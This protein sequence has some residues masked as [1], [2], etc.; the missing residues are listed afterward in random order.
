MISPTYKLSVSSHPMTGILGL[1]VVLLVLTSQLV[2]TPAKLAAKTLPVRQ[3]AAVERE[4]QVFNDFEPGVR[5]LGNPSPASVLGP[6]LKM[7]SL[8][9]NRLV[10]ACHDGIKIWDTQRN[11]VIQSLPL[12]LRNSQCTA[13]EISNDKKMVAAS[14]SSYTNLN[15][16]RPGSALLLDL[17]L[18]QLAEFIL[19]EEI[20]DN[21]NRSNQVAAI[22]FS[23][24]DSEIALA[25]GNKIH[26]HQV[27]NADL[28][29]TYKIRE[30]GFACSKLIFGSRRMHALG[31]RPKTILLASGEVTD[32]PEA[33]AKLI[34]YRAPTFD[35][36]NKRLYVWNKDGLNITDLAGEGF[37][38]VEPEGM[39]SVPYQLALSKDGSMLAAATTRRASESDSN[40]ISWEVVV[41]DTQEFSIKYRFA[42][43]SG[44]PGELC[45][46][47]EDILYASFVTDAGLHKLAFDDPLVEQNYVYKSNRPIRSILLSPDGAQLAAGFIGTQAASW[48]WKT[49]KE[50][51]LGYSNGF[52]S[53]G[54]NKHFYSMTQS[55]QTMSIVRRD[56]LG[57]DSK[58]VHDYSMKHPVL[59]SLLSYAVGATK[60]PQVKHFFVVPSSVAIDKPNSRLHCIILDLKDGIR[61]HSYDLAKF[62]IQSKHLFKRP[63]NSLIQALTAIED[64]GE[65]MAIANAGKLTVID[66][67]SEQAVFEQKSAHVTKLIFS[68]QGDWLA[69]ATKRDVCILDVET[70]KELERFD[71]PN[72]LIAYAS[73]A[74]QLLVAA[75][76]TGS[77]T[78]IYDTMTWDLAF[79]HATKT[80]SKAD[81]TI[82]NDGRRV[83]FALSDC[84]FELWD[85][86]EIKR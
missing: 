22:S 21:Q 70:G 37:R 34:T 47:D 40:Q 6:V 60:S 67:E 29:T 64:S 71:I 30:Q 32:I 43:L 52:L 78:R 49:G 10:V 38:T 59:L 72:A 39:A 7:L 16:N 63:S 76:K 19:D 44:R 9:G 33:L 3:A 54:V 66:I 36:V 17:E 62:E 13:L 80:S 41:L 8:P 77:K 2:A 23:P 48:D 46:S 68:R 86:K 84:R 18:N 58:T 20:I 61:I 31:H 65:R 1:S 50:Y 51:R 25:A 83:A 5:L 79:E 45:F 15:Q 4:N 14:F 85:L 82:S 35:Y 53:R 57:K 27:S 81:A 24:D 12:D 73:D 28:N 56:Y 42:D 74:G 11:A 75:S 26:V 55:G 69:V